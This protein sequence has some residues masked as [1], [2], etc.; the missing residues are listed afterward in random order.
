MIKMLPVF[1]IFDSQFGIKTK[2]LSNSLGKRKY[3]TIG[4]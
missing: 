1:P 3:G 4:T 2:D